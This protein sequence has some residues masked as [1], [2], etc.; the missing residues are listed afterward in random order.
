MMKPTPSLLLFAV[1]LSLPSCTP[2]DQQNTSDQKTDTTVVEQEPLAQSEHNKENTSAQEA[3]NNLSPGKKIFQ[4]CATCHG[5]NAQGNP[6]LKT[7]S[8][9]SQSQLYIKDQ[10]IKFQN[11]IRGKATLDEQGH[12]MAT[13]I[14]HLNEEDFDAV[15][16]YIHSLP[17]VKKT[18]KKTS[19]PEYHNQKIL[20]G[21]RI[22]HG[23]GNCDACHGTNGE[24][25]PVMKSPKLHLL[26]EDYAFDQLM[27]FA[28]GYR[29]YSSSK[30]PQGYQMSRVINN[31]FL[32]RR[33][34]KDLA[35]YIHTLKPK[36]PNT[37]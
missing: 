14:Q 19:S 17:R 34:M 7:P 3:H 4:H 33:D 8:L 11:G 25:N 32:S 30:D 20:R 29:G 13:Q 22:F 16:H 6:A 5:E 12:L 10:L 24:G 21:E 28:K 26:S 9:A 27:K 37:N 35:A 1:F 18:A 23:N 2:P 36:E 31:A 15:S